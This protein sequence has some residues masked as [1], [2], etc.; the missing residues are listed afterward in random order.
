MVLLNSPLLVPFQR[1]ALRQYTMGR[2]LYMWD[3]IY[4]CMP[5]YKAQMQYVPMLAWINAHL[6]P[7]KDLVYTKTLDDQYNLYSDIALYQANDPIESALN[8]WSLESP[9]AYRHLKHL[10]VTYVL[11]DGTERNRVEAAQVYGHLKEVGT[12]GSPDGISTDVLYRLE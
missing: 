11:I 8:A 3:Y 12:A 9:D 6:D 7:H 5:E 1:N 4:G 2:V 10:G